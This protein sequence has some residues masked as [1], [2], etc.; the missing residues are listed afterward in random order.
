MAKTTRILMDMPVTVEICDPGVSASDIDQVFDYFISIDNRFSTFKPD[1]EISRYNQKKLTYSQLS[2][3]MKLVLKLC[4]DTKKATDGYFDIRRPDGTLDPS[5]LVKGWAILN[6]ANLIKSWGFKNYYVDAGGDIQVN[7]LNSKGLPWVIG[8]RNPQN[9]HQNVK[10]VSIGNRGIATS[11]TYI[12]GQ[13][14]YDPFD[15]QPITDVVSLTVI[16]PD[17]YQAD[18]FATAAFAM[19]S[20]GIAFIATLK[21]FEAYSI[22]S[23]GIATFTPGFTKYVI[24]NK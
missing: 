5:G 20:Q 15:P 14:V 19:R 12:R 10:I 13:H 18:R 21:D 7:G 11:G 8:I 9:R 16:G 3:D 1:S 24:P 2:N 17:I 23:Q 6:A 4:E 22:N